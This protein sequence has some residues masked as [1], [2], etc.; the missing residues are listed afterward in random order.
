[1]V[2]IRQPNTFSLGIAFKKERVMSGRARKCNFYGNNHNHQKR[3]L[4][5]Q[6]KYKNKNNY[7]DNSNKALWLP[8]PPVF[9]GLSIL[10]C[11]DDVDFC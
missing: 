5:K 9:P 6:A 7:Y 10:F 2:H 1:M 8:W 11:K 3:S 4:K